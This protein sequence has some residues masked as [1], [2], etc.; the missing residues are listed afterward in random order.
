MLALRSVT[1][2]D[3]DFGS[4]SEEIRKSV[5]LVLYEVEQEPFRFH[6]FDLISSNHVLEHREDL[7]GTLSE[8]HRIAKPN[9][10]FAFTVSTRLWLLLAQPAQLCWKIA[11]YRGHGERRALWLSVSC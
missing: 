4:P 3:L 11:G 7:E 2:V 1:A 5:R 8:I 10:L 6:S 9:A